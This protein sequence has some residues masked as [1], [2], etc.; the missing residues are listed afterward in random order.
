MRALILKDLQ[1][2][3]CP[4][5]ALAVANGDE[6]IAIANRVMP[7]FS[8]IVV[9]QDWHPADH[10]CFAVNNPGTKPGDVI[11]INGL[12]QVMWPVH[13]VQDTPGAEIHGGLDR[14]K[15]VDVFK[16]GTDPDYDSYSA[17]FDNGRKKATGLADY[18]IQRW[19]K[20][21]YVMGLATDY[22]VKNT[23]LDAISLG[24][25]VFVIE[26]GCRAVELKPGDGE[27][28]IDEMRA[29]GVHIVESGAIGP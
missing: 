25:E 24:F 11:E 27:A 26:D 5:G 19:I 6:T 28:A 14:A 9:T 12:S 13:C 21:V 2:D 7:H 20:Q 8:T 4:G 10:K 17:F 1:Y 16:K 29:A 3:F 18:L 15:V 22:C 23:A